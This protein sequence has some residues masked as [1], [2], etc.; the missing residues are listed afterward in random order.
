MLLVVLT[1]WFP[2]PECV[3]NSSDSSEMDDVCLM[4]FGFEPQ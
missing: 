3:L 2:R 4:I 1:S